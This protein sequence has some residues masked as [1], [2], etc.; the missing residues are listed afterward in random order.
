V[1]ATDG[2]TVR[3]AANF[4]VC[5]AVKEDARLEA[6]KLNFFGGAELASW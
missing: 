3:P 5:I 4:Q 1:V 2:K 6:V